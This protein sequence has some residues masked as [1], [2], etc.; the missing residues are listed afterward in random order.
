MAWLVSWLVHSMCVSGGSCRRF[1][2]FS[3]AV[4]VCI[5]CNVVDSLWISVDDSHY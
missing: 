1:V 4:T 3:V 5:E 2:G